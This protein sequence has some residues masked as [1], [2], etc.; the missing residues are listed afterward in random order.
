M[1]LRSNTSLNGL[2]LGDLPRVVSQIGAPMGWSLLG[3]FLEGK[4]PPAKLY[5]FPNA[6][7]L[8]AAQR[9]KVQEILRQQKA[10]ALFFY[11]PG[12]IDPV[13]RTSSMGAVRDLTGMDI[14][15]L[16]PPP[17]KALR[18]SVDSSISWDYPGGSG[19]K[20]TMMHWQV[21]PA[22]GVKPLA[23]YDGGT[24]AIAA[25]EVQRDGWRSVYVAVPGAPLSLLRNCARDAGVWLY[26]EG[27]DTVLAGGRFIGIHAASDGTKVLRLPH[28]SKV[29]D[30]MTGRTV[31]TGDHFE[32][33]MK[34]GETRL[35]WAETNEAPP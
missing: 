28:A 12:Y 3:S 19:K 14:I 7:V 18:L 33:P 8:T 30:V 4:V 17:G 35:F 24:P 5:I 31:A 2:L 11:A 15:P 25:A 32:I 16:E 20:K 21:K 29:R 23:L 9:K 22:P 6:F 26:S 27:G 10:T 1:Y 13:A 34:L